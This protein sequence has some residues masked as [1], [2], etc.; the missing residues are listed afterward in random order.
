MSKLVSELGAD[1]FDDTPRKPHKV[2]PHKRNYII[3]LSALLVGIIAI[4]M[5]YFFATTDWLSDYANMTYITY[6]IN[7]DPDT[8]GIY[9]GKITASIVKVDY[10]SGY[11]TSF[12]V[13]KQIK[14]YPISRIE[15]EAFA[16]CKRIKKLTIQDNITSI[17]EK[18]FVNC[19]ELSKI[20]FSK[21]LISI[22]N[23][24]FKGTAF[25]NSWKENEYVQANGILLYVNEDR[26][27]KDNGASSLILVKDA[28]STYINDYPG[29][30][31][32]S[33][34]TISKVG[35]GGESSSNTTIVNWMDGIFQGFK[36]VKFVETPDYLVKVP[37]NTFMNCSALEKVVI[38]DNVTS[39]GDEA[40]RDCESLK[41]ISISTSVASIGSYA[42]AG[43]K[44]LEIDSLHEGLKT[45]GGGIFQECEAI[46]DFTIPSSLS[47]I[48]EYSFDRTSLSNITFVNNGSSITDINEYAFNQT[49]FT[50]FT[51]PKNTSTISAGV[52]RNCDNLE[53]VFVY[54]N[55]PTGLGYAAFANCEAFHSLKTLDASGNVLAKCDDDNTVYFPSTIRRT[56]KGGGHQFEN[57][58][59]EHAIVNASINS[60]GSYIFKNCALL[61]DVTFENGCTLRTVD[62]GAFEGCSSLT[63]VLF[64]NLVKS[65][66]IGTFKNCVSLTTVKLPECEEWTSQDYRIVTKKGS[67]LPQYYTTIKE[68]IFEGCTSLANLVIPSSITKISNYA[69]KNC[70]SMKTLFV[71][72]G[73]TTIS[74]GAFEG[75]ENLYLAFEAS[76]ATSGFAKDWANGLKGYAFGSH[77]IFETEDFVYSL[78]TDDNTITIVEY[79]GESVPSTLVIPNTIDGKNVTCIKD[80][81]LYGNEQVTNVT[82]PNSV[83]YVGK[84]AF[85]ECPNLVF[86]KVENGFKY[87]ASDNNEYAAIMESVTYENDEEAIFLLNDN[88][89]CAKE[90]AFTN[91]Q[92]TFN[93]DNDGNYLP[94]ENNEFF[95]LVGVSD[96]A[97]KNQIESLAVNENTEFIAEGSIKSLA[98]LKSVIVSDNVKVVGKAAFNANSRFAVYSKDDSK[99]EGWDYEWNL[100]DGNTY[101]STL[102]PIEL[103]GDCYRIFDA[104][105]NLDETIRLTRSSSGQKVV[106]IPSSAKYVKDGV[107][108]TKDITVISSGFLKDDSYVISAYISSSIPTIEEGAFG[109]C[110][111]LV[112]Y[113][114]ST[115]KEAGW[116][117][118]W[119]DAST[120]VYWNVTQTLNQATINDVV[121]TV[122]DGKAVISGHN[123]GIKSAI[124]PSTVKIGN[125][126][127]AVESI[128]A[129]AF[130]NA[131]SMSSIYIPS[132][133]TSISNTS[134]EGCN[135]LTVYFQG[136]MT[137]EF[138]ENYS[139]PVYE[140]VALENIVTVNYI[141]YLVNKNNGEAM[142]TSYAFGLANAAIPDTI[143]DSSGTTYKVTSI[144]SRAF[145][146]CSGL[147]RVSFGANLKTIGDHA[148]EE[149]KGL[150]DYVIIPE[151]VT[152][153]G[154]WAF[155]LTSR[156]LKIY[157]ET[158]QIPST[159]SSEWDV[160]DYDSESDDD[161]TITLSTYIGLNVGWEY[162]NNVPVEIVV[163]S[164]D[165]D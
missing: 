130:A 51:F 128:G 45:I 58:L 76:Q 41:T 158:T 89:Q 30:V 144:G 149:C 10:R 44:M 150:T 36:H 37:S 59:V 11:P 16:G 3:G 52:L 55:G 19:K 86:S 68:N 154:D 71:P 79:K 110:E 9:A 82:L 143:T 70:S 101:W 29:S 66:G 78:N 98:K 83:T 54:D 38:N 75:C 94:S 156:S 103:T 113:C 133:I 127:Y 87:L 139:R 93:L 46:T 81:F 31:A 77:G 4:A 40:F 49:L 18:A 142:A 161:S 162:K 100:V 47:V 27:L 34:K 50:T 90:S 104:C 35:S 146:N 117:D 64:P 151:N 106:T 126:D 53:E 60:I 23:D 124:I 157:V 159:W 21:N 99:P 43:D 122:K 61:Q 63:S 84:G 111:N 105:L 88:V 91:P 153:V 112:I 102:G 109:N 80:N 160:Y 115:S 145:Q 1:V 26:L 134:F 28:E 32:L 42:F 118:N 12:L 97:R 136:N 20:R 8:E 48:P 123:E 56:D 62:E 65:V 140:N 132:S 165:E 129:R 137:T 108:I 5:V 138:S 155:A 147:S 17:G 135:A 152:T 148:F 25:M 22:G 13:P 24:A 2:D 96:A 119:H 15:D 39:I 141:E 125:D 131:S 116:D 69:F 72:I 121:Y 107:E 114:E 120:P 67:I 7:T 73:V 6:G 92:I 57:T 14:G 74:S 164:N 85:E 95:A 163:D 33:L